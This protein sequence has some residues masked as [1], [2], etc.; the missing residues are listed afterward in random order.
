MPLTRLIINNLRNLQAVELR[1]H[2]R[3]N[4]IYGE[5][6][7]GKT[8]LL[9]GVHLLGLGR[10]FRSHRTKPLIN[11]E[12][13]KLTVFGELNRDGQSTRIGVEKSREGDTHLRVD[14]RNVVSAAELAGHLPVLAL[15]ADSFALV[16]G[17]PKPRRQ[18]LDW[19]AFHVEPSFMGIW[20]NLQ[21][22]LKHRNSL[23]RRGRISTAELEPWDLQLGGLSADIDG[24]RRAS[25]DALMEA[26]GPP[27][28]L[29]PGV[30]S[31]EMSYR[32]G[33]RAGEDYRTILEQ[34]L[35]SDLQRGFTQT[36]PHR[37]DIR[38]T[39]NGENA[40][41]VLSRG[42][43]KVLVAALVVGQGRVF[44]R[45]AQRQV[46]YLVDDLPA[47]LDVS[48]SRQLGTWL[49]ELD[50][51]VFVTGV[52]KDSLTGMWPSDQLVHA[53]VFH[54]EHGRVSQE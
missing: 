8:S 23:V 37:A 7:S 26:L 50:A 9:E 10:S 39:V 28:S 33:W 49:D 6:G 15:N 4:I 45:L 52:E 53:H 13:D 51:Q 24:I 29:L 30:G 11:Y 46:V 3:L 35:E 1:T 47:E 32:R 54:V 48:H 27:E 43:Q 22:C 20:R 18:L 25:F 38:I 42:Q 17:P 34:S 19:I 44:K 41:E 21:H 40:A 36:G 16:S 14:G 5:N 2:S 12:A 31:L